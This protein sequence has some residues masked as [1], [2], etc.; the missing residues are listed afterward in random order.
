MTI[1]LIIGRI[2]CMSHI[3]CKRN[4]KSKYVYVSNKQRNLD[5]MKKI[6]MTVVGTKQVNK[7]QLY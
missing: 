6:Q 1:D 5:E 3:L 4:W 2:L 7:S